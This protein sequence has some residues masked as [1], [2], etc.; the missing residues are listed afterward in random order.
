MKTGI[1]L[2]SFAALFAL[3]ATHAGP[4]TNGDFDANPSNP[5]PAAF[6]P[7]VVNSGSRVA[8]ANCSSPAG[9]TV[10]CT[11]TTGLVAGMLISGAGLVTNPPNSTLVAASVTATSFTVTGGTIT[12]CPAALTGSNALPVP[13]LSVTRTAGAFHSSPFSLR[14][15]GRDSAVDGAKQNISVVNGTRYTVRFRINLDAPAQVRC[16]VQL[17][18]AGAP[19]PFVMA[20]TVVYGTDV[21]TWV[22]VQGTN[23]LSTS[24]TLVGAQIF[25]A[26]DQ[27]YPT[28][29][30]A[31]AGSFPSYYLDDVQMAVDTDGDG[32]WDSEEVPGQFDSDPLL[33]DTDGDG[34]PDKWEFD[35]GLLPRVND[36][37]LDPDGDGHSNYIEYWANTDPQSLSSY[38]GIPSDPQ[39]SA[40]TR[41]L[42]YHLQTC[43]ARATG[44]RR[45]GQHAQD[46]PN[47]NDYNTYVV[48]LN[49]LMTQ[50]GAP[51]WVSVLGIAAEGPSAAQP[52][53]ITSS[54]QVGRDYMDAGGLVVL[55]WTPRNPWTNGSNGDHTGVDINDLMTPGTT[56]N[57][58]M[59]GWMATIAAEL[60]SFGPERPVIFRPFSEMNG[61]WNWYGRLPQDDFIA[62]Y[63]WLRGYF[64]G[65]NLHNI[66]W[67]LEAH[68]GAAMPLGSG[69]TGVSTDYYWPGDDAI[70]L[71]GFSNYV[72]NWVPSF[73]ANAASRLHPKAFAITEGGPPINEDDVPNG[74]NSIYLD[75][76]DTY[77][78]RAAFFVVWNSFPGGPNIAIKDNANY[79]GLLTDTRVTNRESL[80]WRAPSGLTSSA[81]SSTQFALGWSGTSGATGY[82][83]ESSATGG[84]PW[85]PAGTSTPTAATLGGFSAATTRHFRVRALY[86]G[87]DS[88]PLSIASATTWTLFQQWK[89]DTLG[90]FAAPDLGDDD[91]DGLTT[92]LEYGL[93]THPLTTS[94]PPTQGIVNI[95]S[96]S[97]LTLTFRR[98]IGPSDAGYAVE[99]TSDLINGAWLPDPVQHGTPVD[100]GDGTETV[101]F[102]DI[103]PIGS[104]PARFLRIRITVQ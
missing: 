26:V 91:H 17:A 86:P 51:S 60:A 3:G 36:A 55:H 104:A 49:T 62:L 6:N 99:A 103:V 90:N 44:K 85:L 38:P 21:G 11:S 32:L 52:L 87:G 41:A 69:N 78:P 9:T 48:G 15:T 61:G 43:T 71:L 93:G 34:M 64:V 27:V 1:L 42:I 2:H 79:Y 22:A 101:T 35:H 8:L 59:T 19:P 56:A 14:V 95:S 77:Y 5:N 12:T 76:L 74:Y 39:A 89:S 75:A 16:I 20:E 102:R 96:A 98:R 29:V 57:T 24:G 40:A 4:I 54:A 7:W 97:Y 25:F 82:A 72:H 67:C 81:S 13:T 88:A 73:D 47:S 100:N 83:L 31:P 84:A 28:G 30:P 66:V 94:Q 33:A 53:Q 46:I 45:S 23:T 80:L 65:Q 37:A 92:L 18:G 50:A 63:R 10:N 68:I 70:D 58:R